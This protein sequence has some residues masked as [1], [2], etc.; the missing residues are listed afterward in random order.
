MHSDETDEPLWNLTIKVDIVPL[1]N[2][3]TSAEIA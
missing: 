3:D 2:D 1:P